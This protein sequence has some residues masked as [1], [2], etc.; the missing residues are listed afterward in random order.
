MGVDPADLR[1]TMVRAARLNR[2]AL[3]RNPTRTT[4]PLTERQAETV[5]KLRAYRDLTGEAMPVRVLAR[6]L[7]I[8][9]RAARDRLAAIAAKGIPTQF[10]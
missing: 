8:S 4:K 10:A 1:D 2:G 5:A 7:S 6:S 9:D 3:L